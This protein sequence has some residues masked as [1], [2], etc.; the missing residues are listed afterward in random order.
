MFV[1]IGLEK[2]IINDF[3]KAIHHWKVYHFADDTSI[4]YASTSVKK[5]NKLFNRDIKSLNNW[6]SANETSLNVGNIELIIS[7]SP[8][9]T[10]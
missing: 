6:L 4:F 9:S 2:K 3:H 7:K 10:S 5:L 1:N 8:K